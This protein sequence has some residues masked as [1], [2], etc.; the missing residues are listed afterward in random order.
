MK[1]VN[2]SPAPR[3]IVGVVRDVDDESIEPGQALTVYQSFEQMEIWGGRLFVHAHVDPHCLISPV[4]QIIRDLSVEQPVEHAATL[5]DIRAEVL[6]PD[7]QLP[8]N[9]TPI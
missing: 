4:T 2:I 5:A 7:F 9:C 6:E 1:F 3:R 8:T